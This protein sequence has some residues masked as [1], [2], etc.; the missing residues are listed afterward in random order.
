MQAE[1]EGSWKGEARSVRPAQE[2]GNLLATGRAS[3]CVARH[4]FQARPHERGLRAD[5]SNLVRVPVPVVRQGSA[6]L[7]K[8][9]ER[10]GVC[11]PQDLRRKLML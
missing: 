9:F 10:Y 7:P 5:P 2:E 6:L 11:H 8:R 1:P 3:W 4:G